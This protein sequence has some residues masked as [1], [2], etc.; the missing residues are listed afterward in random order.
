[1][2]RRVAGAKQATERMVADLRREGVWSS[3]DEALA[4]VA[5]KLAEVLDAGA[6]MATAAVAR[7]LRATLTQLRDARPADDDVDDWIA[8]VSAS[9]QHPEV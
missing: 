8:D 6:G 4:A 3:A 7:E 2:P 5:F 1:M 9:V